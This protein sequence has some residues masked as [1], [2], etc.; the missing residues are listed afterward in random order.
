M[1]SSSLKLTQVV[2]AIALLVVAGCATM[3]SDSDLPRPGDGVR[4]YRRHVADFRSALA[5]C[6][7][8][9]EKLATSTEKSSASAHARVQSSA[10]WLEIVSIKARARADALE[11]RGEEYF[12]EWVEEACASTDEASRAAT[13]ARFEGLRAQ[14]A[15][16]RTDSRE[17]R[18]SSRRFFGYLRQWRAMLGSAPPAAGLEKARTEFAPAA[19]AGR[20]ALES[21]NQLLETLAT[22]EATVM[23]ATKP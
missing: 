4:E 19:A 15:S 22:A 11:A 18:E 2:G 17:V 6:V 20:A 13:R 5:E 14:F 12:S 21:V 23:E 16:V 7:R 1:N 3:N 10:Q 9:V 8:A